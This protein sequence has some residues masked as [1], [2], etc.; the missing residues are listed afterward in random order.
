MDVPSATKLLTMDTFM[1]VAIKHNNQ[2]HLQFLG[3][4][5]I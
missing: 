3:I 1:E 4:V 5:A 2:L